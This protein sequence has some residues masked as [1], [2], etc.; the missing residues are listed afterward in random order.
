MVTTNDKGRVTHSP[1]SKS[2]AEDLKRVL[3]GATNLVHDCQGNEIMYNNE[4]SN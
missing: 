1:L 3:Y 4:R 2:Q